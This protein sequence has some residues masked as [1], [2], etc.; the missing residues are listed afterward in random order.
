MEKEYRVCLQGSLASNHA[1]HTRESF[2]DHMKSTVG[3][4]NFPALLCTEIC[5]Y[6]LVG[7]A[8]CCSSSIW[9]VSLARPVH[10]GEN[11]Y[12]NCIS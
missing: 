10:Q 3:K 8:H 11:T 1:D 7:V 12:I 4:S 9:R 5:C 6:R 2:L